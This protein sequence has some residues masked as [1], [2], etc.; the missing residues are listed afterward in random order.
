MKHGIVALLVLVL[1][2]VFA[3]L[4]L[5]YIHDEIVKIIITLDECEK[6]IS[7]DDWDKA[8]NLA[9]MAVQS[10]DGLKS[11]LALACRSSEIDA[12]STSFLM[13]NESLMSKN[14]ESFMIQNQE[15]MS[16]LEQLSDRE[17]ISVSSV[18]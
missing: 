9:V 1:V 8:E 11:K 17:T 12:I 14:V 18:F 13:I 5:N 6:S 7:N 10:W 15:L 4:G 16:I 2:S 3:Y